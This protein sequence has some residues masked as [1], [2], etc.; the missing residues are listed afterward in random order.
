MD[1]CDR[2]QMNAR[3]TCR[4]R[5]RERFKRQETW[6]WIE[7]HSPFLHKQIRFEIEIGRNQGFFNDAFN[8][9]SNEAAK[10]CRREHMHER[11]IESSGD[12]QRL[13]KIGNLSGRGH[14]L[15]HCA[16]F[17]RLMLINDKY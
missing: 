8:A 7:F 12:R 10:S 14:A 17:E 9:I 2:R 3:C 5:E 15:G 11:L 1:Q 16:A 13:M 4:E 6:I